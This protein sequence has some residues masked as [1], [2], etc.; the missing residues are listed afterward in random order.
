MNG[1]V[2]N[3]INVFTGGIFVHFIFIGPLI[4]IKLI[5]DLMV[6]TMFL[7]VFFRVKKWASVSVEQLH[8]NA[9]LLNQFGII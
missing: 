5:L 9:L 6:W 3:V 1:I 7:N 4:K 8:Q 2:R